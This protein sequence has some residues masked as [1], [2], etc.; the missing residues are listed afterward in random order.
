MGE[1]TK[2]TKASVKGRYLRT[3]VP[4]G[5]VKLLNLEEG[6]LFHWEIKAN[7]DD[8]VIIITPI[9]KRDCNDNR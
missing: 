2:L 8:I 9:K 5:I 1:I 4:S 7:N 3:T 6:D